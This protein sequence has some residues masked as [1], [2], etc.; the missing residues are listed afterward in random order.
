M[1]DLIPCAAC[2]HLI[3]Q[4]T[5]TCPHCGSSKACYGSRVSKAALAIGIVAALSGCDGN[6]ETGETAFAQPDYGV[7]ITDN[8]GDGYDESSDCNDDDPDIHPNATETAGDGVD[9]NCN[10]ED[11]T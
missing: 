6:A 10:D 5:C 4:G 11:D 8:D 2:E 1:P 3:F 7:A 9:S